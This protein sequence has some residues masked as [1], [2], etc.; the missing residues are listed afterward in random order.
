MGSYCS[1]HFDD[2]S[3]CD[4][5]NWV[6]D[7]WAVLFQESDRRQGLC[8]H[9]DTDPDDDPESAI[10]YET[11]RETFLSRLSLLGATESA[12]KHAFEAWLA[13]QRD[14]WGRYADEWDGATGAHAR[15]IRAGLVSLDFEGWKA[16]A[17]QTLYTRYNFTTPYEPTS[18]IEEQFHSRDASYLDFAGYGELITIRALLEACPQVKSIKLDISDL[19]SSGY[20]E[21]SDQICALARKNLPFS[22]HFG[23]TVILGEGSTDLLVLKRGLETMHPSLVDY[24]AFFNHADFGVDGGATYLVKFLKA[25]AAAKVADRFVA[26]FDNDV[27]GVQAVEQA[28]ALNL[29]ANFLIARLPDTDLARCYPTD[30]PAGLADV[31]VNGS[32]GGIELYLGREALTLEGALRPVRWTGYVQAVKKYQGEVE[33]KSDVLKEFLARIDVVKTPEEARA[34]FP[35]LEA[36]WQSIFELVEENVGEQYLYRY[37]K[38]M[39]NDL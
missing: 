30:G 20:Y 33:G 39:Q 5:K 22:Q 28:K 38:L 6:P 17:N 32:A 23:P 8:R 21:E 37:E 10:W 26:V 4:S 15:E 9:D 36:V 35:E 1:I 24:F 16:H 7:S 27:A 13:E 31:D 14:D 12:V 29:P 19:I 3:I 2:L 18:A 25:F 11:D 34:V